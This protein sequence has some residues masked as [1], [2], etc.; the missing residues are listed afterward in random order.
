MTEL[1]GARHPFSL[2][3]V[4]KNTAHSAVCARAATITQVFVMFYTL[5]LYEVSY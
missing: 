2:N 1:K 4:Y 3:A 5:D